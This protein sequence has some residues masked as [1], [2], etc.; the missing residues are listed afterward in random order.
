MPNFV[1]LVVLA[2]VALIVYGLVK[3][4]KWAL[5]VGVGVVL[6]YLVLGLVDR[7]LGC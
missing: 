4:T 2:G 1:I 7:L 6:L 5:W 3:R